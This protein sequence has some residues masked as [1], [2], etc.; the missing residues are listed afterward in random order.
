MSTYKAFILPVLLSVLCGLPTFAAAETLSIIDAPANSTTGIPR[1]GRGMTMQ[2]V[3][4]AF[5]SPRQKMAPV[6]EPPITRWVYEQYT[7][8]FEHDRV[9]H[10]AV[11]HQMQKP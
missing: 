2:Q 7:V 1:P 9:I 4:A 11:H 5:G 6:G 10:S 3:E 8:H